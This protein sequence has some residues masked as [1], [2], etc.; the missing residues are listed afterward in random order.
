MRLHDTKDENI[1]KLKIDKE[2]KKVEKYV[3]FDAYI[4]RLPAS[5]EGSFLGNILDVN[6]IGNFGI[7]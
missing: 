4:F 1:F 5:A 7:F 6:K 3:G 2:R